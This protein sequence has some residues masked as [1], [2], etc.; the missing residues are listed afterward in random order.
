MA[1]DMTPDETRSFLLEGTRTGKLAV[2]RADGRPH[3]TPTWFT[4]D[5]DELVLTTA[6]TSIKAK[7]IRRDPSVAMCVDDQEPP[8]SYVLVEGTATLSDDLD[9]LQRCATAVGG[10]YMGA[11]RAD[12][13]GA[14]NAVPGELVVRIT[15]TRIVARAEI[16]D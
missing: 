8:Y 10:R 4:L 9:E 12:E 5:G 1:H 15:P 16:A 2:S 7:A 11:D 6:E 3:V 13:F 14:R